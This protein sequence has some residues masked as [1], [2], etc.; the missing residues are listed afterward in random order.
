MALKSTVFKVNLS[1]S[2]VNRGYYEDHALILARHPSENDLRMFLRIATFAM[3][4]HEHLQFTK[5]LSEAD[6]PDLWQ[7]DLTGAIQHWIELGQPADKRIRQAS[8]KASQV[9]IVTYPKNAGL[10]WF[11]GIKDQL[12][13][14]RNLKVINLQILN[15]SIISSMIDRSMNLTCVIDGEDVMLTNGNETVNFLV[16]HLKSFA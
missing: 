10:V 12:T 6:E 2:D 3:N 1:I 11:E 7:I 4:A 15:E 9:T 14:F 5:G 16:T 13:R 8:G